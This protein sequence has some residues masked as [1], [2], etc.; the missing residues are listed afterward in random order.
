M[1]NHSD[2]Q[3]ENDGLLESVDELLTEAD[4]MMN[5]MLRVDFYPA[6][7][8]DRARFRTNTMMLPCDFDNPETYRRAIGMVLISLRSFYSELGIV[9]NAI[10][11]IVYVQK[12]S[13]TSVYQVTTN[14]A[15]EGGAPLVP[16]SISIVD[17]EGDAFNVPF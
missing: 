7:L 12:A 14:A 17:W 4:R 16:S 6:A 5:Y 2:D 13:E 3:H 1:I 15:S 9:C 8:E 10:V 11:D